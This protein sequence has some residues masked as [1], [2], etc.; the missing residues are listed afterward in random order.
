MKKKFLTVSLIMMVIAVI[1]LIIA[2]LSMGSTVTLPF[3]VEQL[4]LFYKMYL[5]V[6]VLLFAVSFFIKDRKN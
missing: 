6:M 1:F 5:I 3:T 4:H 2:F